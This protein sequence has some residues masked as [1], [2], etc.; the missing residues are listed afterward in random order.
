MQWVIIALSAS[1]TGSGEGKIRKDKNHKN[2]TTYIEITKLRRTIVTLWCRFCMFKE[3]IKDAILV[4]MEMTVQYSSCL[5]SIFCVTSQSVC[6]EKQQ[7]RKEKVGHRW[8]THTNTH[9]LTELNPNLSTLP[10]P[11][12]LFQIA[13]SCWQ[14]RPKLSTSICVFFPL[15]LYGALF[16]CRSGSLSFHFLCDGRSDRKADRLIEESKN[17]KKQHLLR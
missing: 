11:L 6:Q 14:T 2:V 12:F 13:I 4:K 1:V 16:I 8:Q 7:I 10:P 9:F 5:V 3:Y 15:S 17:W